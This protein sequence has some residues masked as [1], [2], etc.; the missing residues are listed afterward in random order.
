MRRFADRVMPVLQRDPAF[1]GQ[2]AGAPLEAPVTPGQRSEGVF[3][4]A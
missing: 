2:T 4:P 1:A 3:A